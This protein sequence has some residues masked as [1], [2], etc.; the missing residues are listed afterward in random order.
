MNAAFGKVTSAEGGGGEGRKE[1]DD[2][3]NKKQ[4]KDKTKR[5]RNKEMQTKVR[6]GKKRKEKLFK[7]ENVY[8]VCL[9]V[10]LSVCLK[11]QHLSQL[12]FN[13][14]ATKKQK[15]KQKKSGQISLC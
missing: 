2:N 7:K 13:S 14:F 8:V 5:W 3:K 10:C 1:E 15:Q 11:C 6:G 4:K 9:S 12:Q